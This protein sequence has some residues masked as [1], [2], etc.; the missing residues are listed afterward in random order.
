MGYIEAGH[1]AKGR[2]VW[3]FDNDDIKQMYKCNQKKKKILLLCYTEETRKKTVQK[4]TSS[5]KNKVSGRTSNYE[6]QLKRSEEVEGLCQQL[7]EKHG[8]KYKPEQ[9]R[10]WAHMFHVGTHDTLEE[11]PDNCQG[12]P[13]VCHVSQ[14][15]TCAPR[16]VSAQAYTYYH[17]FLSTAG[18]VLQPLLISLTVTR[19]WTFALTLYFCLS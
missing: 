5:D 12:V 16:F 3:L 7:K 13:P 10:T 4:Q 17:A 19:N 14:H 6:S 11:P 2:K 8:S 18:I 9:I 1:G 15:E